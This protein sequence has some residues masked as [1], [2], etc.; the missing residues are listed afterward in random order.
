MSAPSSDRGGVTQII[1]GLRATGHTLDRVWDGGE[2][3]PV[4]NE[5]EALD[6]IFAVDEAYLHVRLPDSEREGWVRFVLGN[7]PE[8]VVCD[9]TVNLS[10]AIDPI[11]DRWWV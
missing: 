10:D 4:V 8:E 11:T 3:V 1:R 9:Y 5:K 7:D 6:A 2:N